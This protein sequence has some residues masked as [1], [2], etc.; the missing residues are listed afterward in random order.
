M[1]KMKLLNKYKKMNKK[2]TNYQ[3]FNQIL[4]LVKIFINEKKK[5]YFVCLIFYIFM[6]KITF[7][8]SF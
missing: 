1:E 6:K 7:K 3:K 5:K 2:K 4:S 8:K